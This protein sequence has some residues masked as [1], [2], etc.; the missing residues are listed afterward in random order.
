MVKIPNLPAGASM[1][2]A[3][4]IPYE[5]VSEGITEH[6]TKANLVG[7]LGDITADTVTVTTGTTLPAGDI[8]TA[9]LADDAVTTAKI[10]DGAATGEKLG[11]PVAFSAYR[12]ASLQVNDTTYASISPD[13]EN[14]DFGAN[15]DTST[16]RFTAPYDGVYAFSATTAI[17]SS[18]TTRLFILLYKNGALSK[19]IGFTSCATSGNHGVFGASEI[20]LAAGDYVEA[21][22]YH[23]YGSVRNLVG[24]PQYTYFTGSLVGRT[25]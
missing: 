12:I 14:Y 18:D 20:E 8:G 19:Q 16:G 1:D 13:T 23:T 15:F 6:I 3:D 2:D 22:F 24:G 5:D 25:D 7:D 10:D 11:T 4:L 9:D 17:S 21:F